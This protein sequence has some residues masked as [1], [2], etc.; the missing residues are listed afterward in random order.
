MRR[1]SVPLRAL[2]AASLAMVAVPLLVAAM[3]SCGA[4]PSSSSASPRD[5]GAEATIAADGGADAAGALCV[6]GHPAPYPT[7]T[8]IALLAAIPDLAFETDDP[9]AA[10]GAVHMHDYF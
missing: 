5:A 3:T 2:L 4:G 8:S 10:G 7:T 1:D 9:A 6:N